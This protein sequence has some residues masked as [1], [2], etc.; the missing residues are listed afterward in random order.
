MNYKLCLFAGELVPAVEKKKKKESKSS[1]LML[2]FNLPSP[3]PPQSKKTVP[4]N[5]EKKESPKGT[6]DVGEKRRDSKSKKKSKRSRHDKDEA[7]TT[8]TKSIGQQGGGGDG[9]TGQVTVA[10]DDPFG[11][12]AALDAW[13]NSDSTEPTVCCIIMQLSMCRGFHAF[14]IYNRKP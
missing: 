11:P 10:S 3:T 4:P 12:I 7:E 8:K 6:P 14:C 1:G 2:E 9:V 5:E 13:L